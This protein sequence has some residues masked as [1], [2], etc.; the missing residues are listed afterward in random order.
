[1][2]LFTSGTG[3]LGLGTAA[4]LVRRLLADAALGILGTARRAAGA[5]ALPARNAFAFL[6]F[7]RAGACAGTTGGARAVGVHFRPP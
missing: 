7:A 3:S 6:A 5:A 1:M 4:A 2:V